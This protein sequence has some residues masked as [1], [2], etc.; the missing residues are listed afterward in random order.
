LTWL[1]K[2][3]S[4]WYLVIGFAFSWAF[5]LPYVYVE[6]VWEPRFFVIARILASFGPALAALLLTGY[7]EGRSGVKRI[8]ADV[9]S[10]S[11]NRKWIAAA[12]G[13]AG[14]AVLIP[15]AVLVYIHKV[16]LARVTVQRLLFL[17]PNFFLNLLFFGSAADEIGWRGFLL[18]KLQQTRSAV[19][20][21]VFIG[22]LWGLW[23][24]PTY[25]FAGLVESNLSP[26]W[27]FLET[28]ALSII[29]T[30]IFNSS[31]SLVGAI[32]FNGV[33][34]TLTQFFLP[35][36]E[37]TGNELVFQQ[38]YTGVLVNMAL[39]VLLFCG[40]KTLVFS[41]RPPKSGGS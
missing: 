28:T 37:V 32:V 24:L 16:S 5:F 31:R 41:Y 29:L 9:L 25:Y 40:G 19:S 2:Y 15:L 6:N 3:A 13:L 1:K 38:L 7:I 33:F 39:I 36:A 22:L 11:R 35:F 34:R 4:L 26:V 14:L 10:V 17:I 20:A 21:S 23:Q 12:F 27:L 18:P 30:W 8:L